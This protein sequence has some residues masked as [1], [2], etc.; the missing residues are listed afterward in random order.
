MSAIE[1]VEAI[2]GGH[3]WLERE[4]L[5]MLSEAGLPCPDT[6]VVLA[7]A[8]DKLVRVDFRFSGTPV[9]VEVL[10]YHYHRTKEHLQ[11]DTQR[12][13]ALI[14]DGYRPYQFTH[15]DL[16]ERPADVLEQTRRALAPFS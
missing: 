14:T 2:R 5:R 10:G 11:R 9:V 12:L 1:G 7:R 15:S 16:V 6:Q 13:N 3:S 8:G 4:Y